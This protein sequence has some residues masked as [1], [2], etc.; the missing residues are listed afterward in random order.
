MDE[1]KGEEESWSRKT[2]H[3]KRKMGDGANANAN[4][5]VLLEL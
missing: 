5:F 4:G 2:F 1:K 3:L